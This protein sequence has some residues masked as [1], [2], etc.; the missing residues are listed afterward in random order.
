MD[1]YIETVWQVSGKTGVVVVCVL[2][3]AGAAWTLL[4]LH[5]ADEVLSEP[6]SER[7][8]ALQTA[9][10]YLSGLLARGW[11]LIPSADDDVT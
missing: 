10:A 11:T 2:A 9:R 1:G 4:I 6:F 3:R 5:G 8:A 7:A